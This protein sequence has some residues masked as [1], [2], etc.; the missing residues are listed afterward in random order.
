MATLFM[1]YAY[2]YYYNL[3]TSCLVLNLVGRYL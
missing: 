1:P 3:M 2:Y